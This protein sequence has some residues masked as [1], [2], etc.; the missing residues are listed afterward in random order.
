MK[1]LITGANGFIGR[2]LA[3]SLKNISKGLD[4]RFPDLK[5]EEIMEADVD[6]AEHELLDYISKADFIFHFAGTNRP[7]DPSEFITG[8]VGSLQFITDALTNCGNRCPIMLSSSTQASLMGRFEDS[9]Y[10]KSK[11]QAENHL[12]NYGEQNNVKLLVYRFPN[13][14]GK[15]ARPN[16]NSAIATFCYNIA[17]DIPI[18]VTNPDIELELLYIDD[19]IAEMISALQGE[20]HRCDYDGLER[21]HSKTGK[22]CYVPLTHKGK[23]GWIAETI[24][25]FRNQPAD[26]FVPTLTNHSLEKALYSTYISYLPTEAISFKPE[27]KSDSRGSFTEL[28]KT[29]SSGQMS[30]NVSAPGI[31]KGEHWH[32]SKIEIFIVVSG[33]ALIQQRKVGTTEIIEKEVWGENP[34]SVFTLPGY[35]HNLINLSDSKELIT[36]IWCNEPFDP[37]NP[38]TFYEKVNINE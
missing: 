2:N 6:T 13:V 1:I 34:E 14:F 29:L 15:W 10:G 9:P 25:K 12:F 11:L 35:T 19:I 20:E 5:I 31:T 38:D 28:V 27:K 17:R 8:N 22:Y 37:N 4:R 7:T 16:Y 32:Q 36:L 18:S 3:F 26:M 24:R 33:H 30:V 23:L 21:I